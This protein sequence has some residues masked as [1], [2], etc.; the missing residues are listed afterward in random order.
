MTVGSH[1]EQTGGIAVA[2]V[3]LPEVLTSWNPPHAL[4]LILVWMN[5]NIVMVCRFALVPY[6]VCRGV[7][8]YDAMFSSFKS[9]VAE[10]GEAEIKARE[11][12]LAKD[13][14][15]REERI[16]KA[17]ELERKKKQAEQEAAA[18]ASARA[19][20]KAEAEAKAKAEAE[21]RAKA[22]AEAKAK[23]KAAKDAEDVSQSV[24]QSGREVLCER[25]RVKRR[26]VIRYV[27]Q[28][29]AL[30]NT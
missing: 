27:I 19:K 11:A 4:V 16:R 20:A 12:K 25:E 7:P 21:A 17:K 23:A 15:E 6:R 28:S 14:Q 29:N 10:V 18:D 8:W 24:S 9:L 1:H 30:R 22:A 13:R 3:P 2:F 26:T 5:K